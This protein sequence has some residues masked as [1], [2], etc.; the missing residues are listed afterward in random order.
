[1][2]VRPITLKQAREFV[3]AHHRHHDMPQGGLWALAL[4]RDEE[5]VG[6][7]I[8][9]RPVSRILQRQGLC[10]VVRLC[11]LEGVPNGCSMLY[12]RCRRVAQAMG[13]SGCITYTLASEGG[14][15][16]RAAGFKAAATTKGG[17]WSRKAR[18]RTDH[19]PTEPKIRWEACA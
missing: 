6:V 10:E 14:A 15:S 8:A 19:H 7:A 11:V 9:G 3:Q 1:M 16:L 13:Y 2:V 4:M 12:G 18:A 5:L 17:S